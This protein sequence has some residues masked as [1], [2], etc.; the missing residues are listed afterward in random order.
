MP[1]QAPSRDCVIVGHNTGDFQE[2]IA[3]R[4]LM[5]KSSGTYRDAQLNSVWVDGKRVTYMDLFNAVRLEV[6]PGA[7]QHDAFD[8]LGLAGCTLASFLVKRGLSAT[9]IGAFRRNRE[10][11]E[12]ELRA[13]PRA[14]VLTTTFYFDPAPIKEV[15]AV[16]R[17]LAPDA[18]IIVGGPYVANLDRSTTPEVSDYVLRDLGADVYVIENQGESS[19]ARALIALR[20]GTSLQLVP[21]LVY[22]EAGRLQRT[23]RELE[24]NKIDDNVVDWTLFEPERLRSLTM[25]RTAISCP[26]ACSFCSYPVRAGE[27][28]V[29][30]V[31]R[32]EQ[33][34]RTLD[35][36]GVRFIDFIDDTFNVPL[37]RFKDLCRMMIRNRFRFR[38]LSYLRCG[39]MDEEAVKLAA[40]S[41]CVGALLGIESGNTEVLTIMNKFAVPAKYRKA[42]R[43]LEDAGI[44]TFALFF[45]G[46]PGETAA[47]VRDSIQLIKDTAPSFFA[48]QMW[49]YDHTTPI[50]QRAAQ[51]GLKGGGYGWRHNSMTWQEAADLATEM[52]REVDTS[53][54]IPQAGFS[55]ETI[56]HLMG[57]GYDQAYLVEFLR[58]GRRILLEGLGD[59]GDISGHVEELRAL[60]ARQ[61][62]V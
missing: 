24:D 4:K 46:F 11:L 42:I 34:L 16:V 59:G 28:R 23:P 2:Y 17:E 36:L 18:A 57:K 12:A 43:W 13:G 52:V 3:A 21:N 19:L 25:L 40:E 33:E 45:V 32:L 61:S 22:R 51:Y 20:D 29:S 53:V 26:F 5:G 47:S 60:C 27:H 31:D 15:M 55:F 56:F 37:G 14:V 8:P 50:H 7:E 48:T 39:N 62:L 38:W 9:F 1:A 54:Y 58:V 49:F 30:E 41:G 6:S 10:R 35:Q 44:K